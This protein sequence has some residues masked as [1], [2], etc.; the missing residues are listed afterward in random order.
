MKLK[1]NDEKRSFLPF[2]V[3][4]GNFS[5]DDCK[6]LLVSKKN[7]LLPRSVDVKDCSANLIFYYTVHN[8][9]SDVFWH[10][11]ELRAM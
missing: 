3:K 11:Y 8:F 4:K 5:K 10:R 2:D 1:N 7:Y 9:A 6:S